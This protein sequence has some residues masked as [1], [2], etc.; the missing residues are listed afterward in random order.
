MT[1]IFRQHSLE[2]VAASAR[3]LMHRSLMLALVLF[4]GSLAATSMPNQ[5]VA[6]IDLQ[7]YMGQWHEI[8][9]L[10]LFFQRKCSGPV[11][12]T[13]LLGANAEIKL[14][15]ICAT[16][17]GRKTVDMVAI[18]VEE[19]PAAFKIRIV[20]A[21]LSW[22]PYAWFEYW[23]IDIDPNYQWAVVGGPGAKHLW[24]LSRDRTMGVALYHRLVER[25]RDRGYPVDKLV[26]VSPLDGA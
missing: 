22:L 24:I 14:H 3:A 25:A 19:Q 18:S 8:A 6:A 13:S 10:P 5:P 23:V 16:R 7:R 15:A 2:N 11:T 17:S 26:I 1:L 20:P 4:S 12:A 9:H 21:W